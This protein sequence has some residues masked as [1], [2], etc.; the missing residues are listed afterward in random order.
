M[1]PDSLNSYPDMDP[2][3]AFEVNSDPVPN[4]VPGF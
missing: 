4:P 2:D 1:D 3:P